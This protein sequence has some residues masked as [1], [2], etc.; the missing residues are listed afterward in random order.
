MGQC[1]II[2]HMGILISLKWGEK[3]GKMINKNFPSVDKNHE[4]VNSRKI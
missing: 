1:Q 2:E 4:L 3:I